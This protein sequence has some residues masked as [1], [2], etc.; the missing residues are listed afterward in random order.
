MSVKRMS[1]TKACV[2]TQNRQ[3]AFAPSVTHMRVDVPAEQ[4]Q[5]H[6]KTSA[7]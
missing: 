5:H 3:A 2:R 7:S 6:R 4:P 1:I